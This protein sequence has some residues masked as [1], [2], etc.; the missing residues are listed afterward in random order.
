M[1]NAIKGK[2]KKEQATAYKAGNRALKNAQA[3]KERHVRRHPNDAQA[4]DKTPAGHTRKTPG[5]KGGWVTGKVFALM[6]GWMRNDAESFNNVP[7][8]AAAQKRIAQHMAFDAAAGNERVYQERKMD[9]A[10]KARAEAKAKR[11]AVRE[12]RSKGKQK[13]AA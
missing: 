6:S 7:R 11:L 1:A 12:K 9:A 2:S 5:A 3:R 10:W 8:G 13:K 4:A